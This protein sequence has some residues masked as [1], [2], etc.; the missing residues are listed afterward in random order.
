[1][2]QSKLPQCTGCRCRQIVA[3]AAGMTGHELCDAGGKPWV[4]C[5]VTREVM[6]LPLAGLADVGA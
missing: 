3:S 4:G 6:Q 2:K 1:M 5:V